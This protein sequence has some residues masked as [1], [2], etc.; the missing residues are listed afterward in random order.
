MKE[1]E[2]S[3]YNELIKQYSEE[4]QR[5]KHN[6]VKVKYHD[7][8]SNIHKKPEFE[9]YGLTPQ[10]APVREEPEQKQGIIVDNKNKWKS[11]ARNVYSLASLN[12]NNNNAKN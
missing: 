6:K 12:T 4:K 8:F 10:Q 7:F 9:P 5:F 1:N 11:P 3:S 2:E